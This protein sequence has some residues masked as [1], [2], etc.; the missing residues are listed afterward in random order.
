LRHGDIRTAAEEKQFIGQSDLPLDERG[1]R[2]ARFWRDWL[3]G[4]QIEQ[5]F[6][7]GLARCM[8][9]ARIIASDRPVDIVSSA[10]LK[11]IRLGRWEGLSFAHVR[12]R[13]PEAFAQRGRSIVHFRPPGG[14]NVADLQRRVIAAF[15]KMLAHSGGNLLIVAHAGVNRVIL[16]HLLGMP[17]ENVFRIGQDLGCL[18]LIDRRPQGLRIQALNL[19]PDCKGSQPAAR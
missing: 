15:E 9:T 11:E 10:A 14:E 6:T 5:V 4:V 2:Q 16:C 19:L 12:R 18:N 7:S 17:L 3:S 1:C 8:E 13:W